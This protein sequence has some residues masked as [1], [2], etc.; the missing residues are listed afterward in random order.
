MDKVF[1]LYGADGW[2]GQQLYTLLRRRRY[3]VIKG[4]NLL[5]NYASLRNEIR[6]YKS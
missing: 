6:E 2:I 5:E 3:L 4:R 1:L